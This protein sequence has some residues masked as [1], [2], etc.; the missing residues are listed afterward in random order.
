V[1][2]KDGLMNKARSRIRVRKVDIVNIQIR[3][4][5]HCRDPKCISACPE[6]ALSKHKGIVTVDEGSCTFCGNCLRVC[7]RLFLNPEGNGILICDV[8]GA[9]VATCP[10]QAMEIVR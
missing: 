1:V 3:V 10:E 7:D 4:C 5:V 2:V 8:C 9:C 6:G